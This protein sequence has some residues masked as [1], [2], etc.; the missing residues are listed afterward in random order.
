MT[1]FANTPYRKLK[2]GMEASAKRLCR[3]DDFLI[4][5]SSSGNH[6]PVHLPK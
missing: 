6:N 2:V 1:T 4:Y 5:A 3:A